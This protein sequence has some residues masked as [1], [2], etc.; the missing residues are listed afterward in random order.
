MFVNPVQGRHIYRSSVHVEL[1]YF[2]LRKLLLR[3][4]VCSGFYFPPSIPDPGESAQSEWVNPRR[5]TQASYVAA[6]L[7]VGANR[8]LI[9]TE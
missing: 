7:Y 2:E 1:K 8:R 4:T 9:G 6:R 3:I 5:I